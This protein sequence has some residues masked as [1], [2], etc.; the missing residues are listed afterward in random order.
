MLLSYRENISLVLSRRKA[1]KI[2]IGILLLLLPQMLAMSAQTE[3]PREYQLKA[4]FLYHFGKFVEWPESSFSKG[5][6]EFCILGKDPF[7]EILDSSLGGKTLKDKPIQ[8]ERIQEPKEAARCQILFISPSEG[9]RLAEIFRALKNGS[10]LTIGE[11]SDFNQK[12]GIIQ[13]IVRD[14]KV[15]FSINSQAGE[16]A[17][18]KISSQLLK[19]AVSD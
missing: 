6:F 8:I 3:D 1:C 19:I 4:G 5:A 16:Q 7:G 15:R 10:V 2:L 18:L 14:N 12:G 9:G 17:K 13:F 11:S